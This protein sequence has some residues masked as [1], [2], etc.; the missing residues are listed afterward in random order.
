MTTI[1]SVEADD[2]PIGAADWL[3]DERDRGLPAKAGM[4]YMRLMPMRCPR[5]NLEMTTAF[6]VAADGDQ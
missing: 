3:I 4:S 5:T 1:A 6:T 2:E